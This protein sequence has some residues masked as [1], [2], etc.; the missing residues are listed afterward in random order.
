MRVG[1]TSW[2]GQRRKS[3]I[4]SGI[5]AFN[6]VLDILM[7][8]LITPRPSSLVPC[9]IT[10]KT[11]PPIVCNGHLVPCYDRTKVAV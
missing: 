2:S 8:F 5:S 7:R 10:Y 1:P 9:Y 3:T 11:S 6:A 4:E